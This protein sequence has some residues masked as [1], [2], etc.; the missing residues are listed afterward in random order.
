M[1]DSE[2]WWTKI[3]FADCKYPYIRFPLKSPLYY[4]LRDEEA[5]KMFMSQA[6]REGYRQ[7]FLESNRSFNVWGEAR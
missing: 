5:I 6:Y 7:G 2:K 4:D 1:S 3:E